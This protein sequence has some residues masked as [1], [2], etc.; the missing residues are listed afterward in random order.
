MKSILLSFVVFFLFFNADI[1]CGQKKINQKFKKETI[2][3]IDTL[4]QQNYIFPDQ[5]QLIAKHLKE[6]LK[7][8]AFNKYE[9]LDSFAVA[10]TKEIRFINNDEHLG[11]WPAFAPSKTK[12]NSDNDYEIYLR[13]YTNIRKQA[14]GFAEVKILNNNIGYLNISFFL[15]ET[16]QTIDSYMNLISNTDALIIDLQNNGGGNPKTVNYLCSYFFK[17]HLL[18]NTMYFRKQNRKEDIYTHEVEGRKLITIPLVI[19]MGPKTFSGAEEFI[20]TMQTQKRAVLIGETTA[21]A[22]N[23][24]DVFSINSNLEIFIPTGTSTN[25]VTKTNWEATGIIPEIKTSAESAYDKAVVLA[26]KLAEEYRNKTASESK[27]IYTE[28]QMIIDSATKLSVQNE[29]DQRIIE[30]LNKGIDLNLFSEKDINFF[31]SQN[32][33]NKPLVAES[34]LKS[35]AILYP[36]SPIALLNYGDM[37][38]LNGKKELALINFAKAVALADE[39]KAPYLEGLKMRYEK[40][41]NSN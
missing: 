38:E 10:L 18:T 30:V 9:L 1:L 32:I 8:G 7:N 15:S 2:F 26:N 12:E 23:P 39:Q 31:G 36:K 14:N 13:N 16:N 22:A 27:A 21:G 28:L 34:I 29:I 35:N 3:K 24:G 19:L 4:L 25:P 20:Y 40:A 33:K 6:K 17:N 5:A 37:L 41:K 11:I